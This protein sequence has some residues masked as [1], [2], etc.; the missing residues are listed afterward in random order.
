MDMESLDFPTNSFGY[1]YS[2]LA[3]HY[4]KDWQ[5]NLARHIQDAKARRAVSILDDPSG[6]KL[7]KRALW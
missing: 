2:S 7:T 3:L 4:K 1:I 5:E 6:G